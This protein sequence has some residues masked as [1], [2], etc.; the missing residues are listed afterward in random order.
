MITTPQPELGG[1]L[2]ALATPFTDD[3]SKIDESR[4]QAHIEH[5]LNDGVHGF[6]LGGSTGEFTA[7]DIDKRKQLI[8]LVVNY[9]NGRVLIVAGISG[10][11]TNVNLT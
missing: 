11:S 9:T 3:G 7:L 5:L 10:L 8:K 4:L 6:V 1:V 2:V